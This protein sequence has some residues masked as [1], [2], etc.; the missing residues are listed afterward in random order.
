M[1]I[2]L[3]QVSKRFQQHWIFKNISYSFVQ[4]NGYALLGANGSGKSTLLRVIA[5][6]QS[7]SKGKV[8]FTD[9]N[10]KAVTT[11][12]IFSKI[13]FS[14]PG[15]E[16]VEELTMREFLDFHFSFKRPLNN[17]RID[18]IINLTGL[19]SAADKPIGDY[20]S[21]MKQRVKLAQAIFSDTPILMLDEP[22]T[23]LDQAGVEQYRE[24]IE[25]YAANRLILVASN[26]VREYFFCREKITL[27][28]FK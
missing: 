17:L 25:T 18:D 11:N 24:W 28:N 10:D 22:C 3:D 14:A 8:L 7:A 1:K 21:G 2:T 9:D 23:N 16:I 5:G 26:D 13:G 19:Q 20:S 27:E 6:M 15:Q 12:Q 4:G